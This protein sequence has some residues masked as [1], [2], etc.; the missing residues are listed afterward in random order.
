MATGKESE[1]DYALKETKDK[2]IFYYY[3]NIDGEVTP[4]ATIY[5]LLLLHALRLLA[6]FLFDTEIRIANGIS[7]F[8]KF[9]RAY[10]GVPDDK[11]LSHVYEIVS[12]TTQFSMT[13]AETLYSREIKHGQFGRIPV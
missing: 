10:I 5:E 1:P 2:N 7:Q 11:I 6:T 3:D 12:S 8:R 4:E 9:L 13:L